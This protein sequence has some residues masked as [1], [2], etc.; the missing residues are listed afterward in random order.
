[1]TRGV[2]GLKRGEFASALPGKFDQNASSPVCEN[3]LQAGSAAAIAATCYRNS[4]NA[5]YDSSSTLIQP[6]ANSMMAQVAVR[7]ISNAGRA[8][9]FGPMEESK[10]QGQSYKAPPSLLGKGSVPMA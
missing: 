6:R 2:L 3:G 9:R 4:I 10:W 7:L 8:R 1:M 5:A